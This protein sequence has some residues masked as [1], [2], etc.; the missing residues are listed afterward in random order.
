MWA[1]KSRNTHTCRSAY[2]K[3]KIAR[4]TE[5]LLLTLKELIKLSLYGTTGWEILQQKSENAM[6]V[7]DSDIRC[8]A[9]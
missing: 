4:F 2:E 7:K 8:D 6:A 9:V 3:R 5:H 1:T